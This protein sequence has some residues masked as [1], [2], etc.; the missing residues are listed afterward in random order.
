[1][2]YH[3]FL[4]KRYVFRRLI[5]YA[6]VLAVAFGVFS[7][8]SVLA[9]M[10][11]FKDEMRARIRGSLSHLS[12][13]GPYGNDLL[14]SP[15]LIEALLALEHVEAAAP[16][17]VGQ[18]IYRASTVTPCEIR[19]IDPVAEAAVGDF[20]AYL[21]RDD[22]IRELLADETRMLGD[23]RIPMTAEEIEAVFSRER[24]DL[25][26]DSFRAFD[27]DSGFRLP[28][29]PIVVGIEV[30]RRNHA[31]IGDI[32]ELQS[33]S[34]RTL[35]ARNEEFL[36]VGSF[37]TGV[38]E[39]DLSWMFIPIQVAVS[40][41]DLFDEE[42]LDDRIS[43]ISVRLDDYENAGAMRETI[44]SVV[45]EELYGDRLESYP[46][47]R[48]WEDQRR[49]LLRAV[50]V[51]KRIISVMMMLIVLFAGVMIFLILTL[52]VIEK[53]RDLG[54]L[55]SLGATRGGVISLFLRQGLTLTLIGMVLGSIG[56]VILVANLNP[57]HDAIRDATG[58]QLF[59]PTIYYLSRIPAKMRV[60]DWGTVLVPAFAFGLLGSLIP[61]VWASR[62]DP[63]K[64]L[65]HE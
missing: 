43:G 41:L 59:D 60:E 12:I 42:Q 33:F 65:H 11:G 2:Q 55:R 37:Q 44:R 32:I 19:G 53:T 52:M 36:V 50:A 15:E 9:V 31:R 16:F 40:F 18:G 25:L 64:A 46:L 61:A 63:I 57:I 20:A 35:E 17:V 6:A 39:Q 27:G 51:E 58:F 14:G 54:V 48:T 45:L 26:F 47:V 29:Q 62:Q 49:N 38:F 34:P 8:I 5:P 21:L 13:F 22:E 4:M 23:E 30:L 28:P 10:E 7:L 56:G 24:R 1:M 3:G